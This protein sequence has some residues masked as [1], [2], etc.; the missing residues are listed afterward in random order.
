MTRSAL[1]YISQLFECQPE[2]FGEEMDEKGRDRSIVCILL[3]KQQKDFLPKA[4]PS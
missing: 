2:L 3:Q 1:Y 4:D